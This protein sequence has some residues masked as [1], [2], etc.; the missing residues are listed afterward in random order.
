M[1][2]F[3]YRVDSLL[4]GPDTT[5]GDHICAA[6][7]PAGGKCTVRAAVMEAM[8]TSGVDII[9]IPSGLYKL[10]P[11][12]GALRI[13]DEVKIQGAGPSN[14]ILDGSDG[15]RR[16]PVFIV[17]Q[18]GYLVA[19]NLTV[20]NGGESPAGGGIGVFAGA[21]EFN[22]IVISDNSAVM[23]GGGGLYIDPN[24][25]VK[26]WR[27]SILR[28]KATG[29]F[30]GGI[31]N[32]GT[33]W[34]FE[35]TIANNESNRAGGIRN[36]G[37][38]YLRNTTVSGNRATSPGAGTGGIVQNGIAHLNNVTITNN[39]GVG[40]DPI[41]NRGGGILIVQGQTTVLT[42]SII[43]GNHGGTGPNAGP[44]DCDG[45]LSPDSKYSLIGDRTGC[46]IPLG[47][48]STFTLDAD[49][50]LA[51]LADNGGPTLTHLPLPKPLVP[52]RFLPPKLWLHVDT[53]CEMQDQ[54]GVPRSRRFGRC[55]MGAVE[56]TRATGRVTGFVLVDA[57]SDTDIRPL[58]QGD[59]LVLADLPSQLSV[60]A[61][62][63]GSPDSVVFDYDASQS[64]AA[65]TGAPY[66]LGGDNGGNYIPFTLTPGFHQLTATPLTSALGRALEGVSQMIDFTVLDVRNAAD[67]WEV[68][69]IEIKRPSNNLTLVSPTMPQLV[70][71]QK[72][73]S[74]LLVR[75]NEGT[76]NQRDVLG[77][78]PLSPDTVMATLG[79]PLG[80]HTVTVSGDLSCWYCTGGKRGEAKSRTFSL[81]PAAATCTRSGSVPVRTI[82]SAGITIGQTPGRQTIM[83]PLLNRNDEVLILIDDAPDLQQNQ[84]RVDIDLRGFPEVEWNKA[85]EAWGSCGSG[86]RID[87]AEA[88]L[89]GGFGVGI[90]CTPLSAS[91][92]FRSGCTN[93]QTM[94]LNQNTTKELLLRKPGFFG[95]W[96]DV[97]VFDSS[98]WAA[99][100]GR[101]VRFIWWKD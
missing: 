68:G 62:V 39:T 4:D 59:I 96:Y 24:G 67:T 80:T 15:P 87:L 70:F 91:N 92:D 23:T 95:F 34:V 28:N 41:G 17:T 85:I 98:I 26:M 21:A 64:M 6:A 83:T 25:S 35:S 101:S 19:N 5:P 40:N 46:T 11:N 47:T 61:E 93:S 3:T 14:T 57:A 48:A 65:D 42:N 82:P 90:I 32:R 99:W 44:N 37:T 13:T 97:E 49:P 18:G 16:T 10:E 33:L 55:D 100:G 86:S 2:A 69:S 84:M 38:I 75:T 88:S 31:W 94:T 8:S 54:R 22:N 45:S 20:Q 1:T 79:V 73:L 76:P 78:T 58:K 72:Q 53:G 63:Q 51:A 60:R 89:M 12:L 52:S 56:V 43:A 71:T 74:N 50:G 81:L 9:E 66:S 36:D 29:A 7:G 30:G 27:S 77:F